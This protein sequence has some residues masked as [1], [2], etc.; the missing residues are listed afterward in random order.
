MFIT[1]YSYSY[2][3]K[4]HDS[5]ISNVNLNVSEDQLRGNVR[6]AFALFSSHS[7]THV[8]IIIIVIAVSKFAKPLGLFMLT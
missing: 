7:A 5:M 6:F 8:A 2:Q 3:I 4:D 1:F